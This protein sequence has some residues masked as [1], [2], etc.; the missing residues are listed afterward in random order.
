MVFNEDDF[1]KTSSQ[2]KWDV[3]IPEPTE[4]VANSNLIE[5][6][7]DEEDEEDEGAEVILLED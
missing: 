7:K 4:I 5:D 3:K 2:I 1:Q 6:E